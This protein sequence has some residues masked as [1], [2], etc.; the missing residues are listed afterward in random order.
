VRAAADCRLS[1]FPIPWL[2]TLCLALLAATP[3]PAQTVGG[4]LVDEGGQP[5]DGTVVGLYHPRGGRAVAAGLTDA[6]G[7]FVLDAPAPGRYLV[8]AERV[9]YRPASAGVELAAGE[10]AEV[11]LTTAVQAFVLAPV[12]V[13]ADTRCVV[14][15]G[16]GLRAYELWEQAAVALRA[17]ALV[18]QQELVEYTI[19]TYRYDPRRTPQTRRDPPRRVRGQPFETLSPAAVAARGYLRERGD[20]TILYGPDAT[21]LLSDEFLD[22]HCLYVQTRGAPRGQVGVAFE[23]V[24]A[25]EKVDIRGTLWLDAGTGELRTV[26][27]EYT[28]PARSSRRSRSRGQVE[29]QRLPSGAWIVSRWNIRTA[30]PRQGRFLDIRHSGG[31]VS[32]ITV[33]Q[34]P[35]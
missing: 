24:G 26:T 19:H 2:L 11:R 8:R 9:G 22:T 27:Y 6:R 21:V 7:R 35:P 4:V 17:A 5:V 15:P 10:R 30:R 12:Q 20:T 29:F 13:S 18:E 33:V 1:L 23:P 32:D 34:G 16:V 3:L 25:R 14:R 28:G 31:E